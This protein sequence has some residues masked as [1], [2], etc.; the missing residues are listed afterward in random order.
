MSNESYN[1]IEMVTHYG[2][3]D[4][5]RVSI[6]SLSAKNRAL[7]EEPLPRVLHSG[8][9]NTR[10]REASPSAIGSMALGEERHSG[11]ALFPECNTRGREALADENWYLTAEGDGAT[12]KTLSPKC[13][14]LELGEESLFPE[15][16]PLA[17]GEGALPRVLGKGTEGIIF[18]FLVF[19]PQFF[20]E[21]T[22]HYFNLLVQN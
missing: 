11:K 19:S 8:K 7:G 21:A 9:K 17:L 1:R 20:C 13:H 5:S 3:M 6:A 4:I 15:C 18:L 12:L 16:L 14:P 22:P 10:G 2:R